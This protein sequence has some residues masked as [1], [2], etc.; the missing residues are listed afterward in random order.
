MFV[1]NL[2]EINYQTLLKADTK[3]ICN[4]GIVNRQL[5]CQKYF[6]AI[7]LWRKIRCFES[8]VFGNSTLNHPM[9]LG[10]I[11]DN[12]SASNQG[13]CAALSPEDASLSP[14]LHSKKIA[15]SRTAIQFSVMGGS[16]RHG[17]PSVRLRYMSTHLQ[18]KRTCPFT[19]RLHASRVIR[20][21]H[22]RSSKR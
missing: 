21:P 20:P 11:K 22:A 15:K 1:S 8:M 7:Q 4:M 16:V 13:E 12:Y 10:C 18:G 3:R 9:G 6:A 14:C 5:L 19:H 2:I 17:R